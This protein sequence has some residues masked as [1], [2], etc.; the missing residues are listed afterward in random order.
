MLFTT[1]LLSVS[2]VFADEATQPREVTITLAG[3][4]L[5]EA[6][7]TWVLDVVVEGA[8]ASEMV[9]A[10]LFHGVHIKQQAL[11]L[12]TGGVARWLFGDGELTEA[13][14]TLVIVAFEETRETFALTVEPQAPAFL[15]TFTTTNSLLAYGDDETTLIAFVAD[16][17]GNPFDGAEL[18]LETVDP[19][20]NDEAWQ[21]DTRYGLGLQSFMSR[22]NPGLLQVEI[23]LDELQN[24][25]ALVQQPGHPVDVDFSIT[26]NCV[27]A[28]GDASI[29]LRARISDQAGFAVVDGT[30][31]QF[32][33]RT[34][35]A[36]AI[37]INGQAD[38]TIPAPS[39]ADMYT[40]AVRT[41]HT[42]SVARL[43]VE[44][45]RC[46]N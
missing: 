41:T 21:F 24:E 34:G 30:T 33:W 44:E 15:E 16:A 20:G 22:G 5:I 9:Q 4:N 1:L 25:L 35:E 17:Q 23:S 39:V 46:V 14:E 28:G 45:D 37:V 13:G 11:V 12:G 6:G 43:R 38:L 18:V 2:F 36:S 31:V 3:E 10:T 40:F 27:L 7:E 19:S 29:T 8:F 26:P 42:S 32:A